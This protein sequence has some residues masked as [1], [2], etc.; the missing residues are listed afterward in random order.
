MRSYSK[1]NHLLKTK[2]FK[3]SSEVFNSLGEYKDSRKKYNESQY[4][5]A[6]EELSKSNFTYASTIYKELGEYKDSNDLYQMAIKKE[7]ISNDKTPPIIHNVPDSTTTT[8]GESINLEAL[9]EENS[10]EVTDDVSED[11]KYVIN[12]LAIDYKEAGIYEAVI[13]AEDEAGNKAEEKM[14][15]YVKDFPVHE[16]YSMATNIKASKLEKTSSGKYVYNGIRLI[17]EEVKDMFGKT[18]VNQGAIYRTYAKALEGFY[19]F[20]NM[21]GNWGGDAVY[22][23]FG[24]DKKDSWGEMKPYVDSV[25]LFII[26]ED[27]LKGIMG[28]FESSEGVE[29]TFDF[30][31]NDYNFTINDLST[32]AQELGISEN[33][34]SESWI[35]L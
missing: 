30:E 2:S 32:I 15:I 3:E 19:L 6:E 22:E 9:L 17:K 4:A 10:V 11:L 8:V 13:S 20:E 26:R 33:M 29:G 31:N 1:A 7:L 12:D 34:S 24:F 21:Y 14:K 28:R 35:K 16:A 25:S 23:I 5:L 18:I 27:S